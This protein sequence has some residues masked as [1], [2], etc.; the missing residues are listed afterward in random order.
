MTGGALRAMESKFVRANGINL[1]YVSAGGGQPIVFV[2]G[3]PEFWRA[4][5]NQL[6]EFAKDRLAIALDM[7]GYNLSDKPAGV[8]AYAESPLVEDLRQFLRSFGPTPATLVAHDWGGVCAWAFAAR[9]PELLDRLVIINSPH[10]ATLVRELLANPAQREAM[11][12]TLL[13]RSARGEAMLSDRN[14]ARLARMF[15]TW[16][17]GGCK[18]DPA[19]VSA[20]KEAWAK[21]GALTS[22]LNYYRAT[23]LHPP[24]PGEPG[25]ASVQFDPAATVVRVPT[26][27][28]WGEKDPALLTCLL[29]GLDEFVP[30]LRIDRIPEGTHWVAHEF[31]DQV[32]RLIR[33]FLA[34]P[35]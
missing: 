19:L 31:P 32:N 14:Y 10:P 17:I 34:Q 33:D 22:A 3:F 2:H 23:S 24:G 5:E 16:E 13:F 18:L 6:L 30:N 8:E 15:E 26:Q 20:Y 12:Y 28:I 21:P 11:S 29:D 35:F 4:W 1:H 25:I 9:H 7:R 27:V